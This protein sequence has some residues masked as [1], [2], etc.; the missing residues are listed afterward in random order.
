MMA[1]PHPSATSAKR[2]PRHNPRFGALCGNGQATPARTYSGHA[3]AWHIFGTSHFVRC[4]RGVR[5]PGSTDDLDASGR[6]YRGRTRLRALWALRPVVVRVHS[7]ACR[8]PRNATGPLAALK[9][10]S[11]AGARSAR[12]PRN[13]PER[14]QAAQLHMRRD[15][16]GRMRL[17]C[18]WVPR[19]LSGG[20][21]WLAQLPATR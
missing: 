14:V 2:A 16:P 11:A 21:L 20:C 1:S 3:G 19:P 15:S 9:T 17:P 6:I 7:S 5:K 8:K 10:P 4:V 12:R 13:D 18:Q